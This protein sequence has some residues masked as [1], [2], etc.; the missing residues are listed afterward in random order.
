MIS[1]QIGTGDNPTG[2]M[3]YSSPPVDAP[4]QSQPSFAATSGVNPNPNLYS[5]TGPGPVPRQYGVQGYQ[6]AG[7]DAYGFGAWGNM[8]D[9]TAQMGVQFG[10][11]AVAAGQ[12]YVE[13]NVGKVSSE[14]IVSLRDT[15]HYN[16]SRRHST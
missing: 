14:L 9:A 5:S 7:A 11:S 8:N 3:R 15:F 2:Y 6:Q 1:G 10:K 4:Q 16:S 12:D 13:K